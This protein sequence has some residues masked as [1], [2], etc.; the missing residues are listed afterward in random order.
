ME[1]QELEMAI[2][3][4][5][6]EIDVNDR[7]KSVDGHI[8]LATNDGKRRSKLQMGAILTALFV[9]SG[10]YSCPAFQS[11]NLQTSI[12]PLLIY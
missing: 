7:T 6:E 5:K 4:A 3:P 8:S 9:R 1:Q 2:R 11:I 10:S 12:P